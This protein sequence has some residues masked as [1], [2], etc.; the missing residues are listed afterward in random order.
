MT[1]A[2]KGRTKMLTAQQEYDY[3]MAALRREPFYF[4]ADQY[5]AMPG[6]ITWFRRHAIEALKLA[7]RPLPWVKDR[8]WVNPASTETY[9]ACGYADGI[10]QDHEDCRAYAPIAV[11][12]Y[13]IA[14]AR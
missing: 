8:N 10:A 2:K 4:P 1:T 12:M 5:N 7:R 14:A 13:R 6:T 3:I 11:G 9:S